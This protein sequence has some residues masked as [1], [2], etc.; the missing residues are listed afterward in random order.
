M[1]NYSCTRYAGDT[2][3]PTTVMA[4]GDESNDAVPNKYA[5]RA[6]TVTVDFGISST[7]AVTTVA[8]VPWV[9]AARRPLAQC[10]GRA[11]TAVTDD[12]DAGQLVT[13]T[14]VN[15]ISE[16]V[17]FDVVAYA[18]EGATGIF[19]IQIIGVGQ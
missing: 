5:A 7:R 15:N 4:V 14:V 2:G 6:L 12:D 9:K 3:V 19:E 18:P 11:W 17:T 10:V 13:R 8:A 1:I 16:G